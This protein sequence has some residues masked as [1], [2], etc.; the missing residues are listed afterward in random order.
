MLNAAALPCVYE[1]TAA[2]AISVKGTYNF[3]R[4]ADGVDSLY[5]WLDLVI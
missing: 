5:V 3:S 1:G 4:G 2:H